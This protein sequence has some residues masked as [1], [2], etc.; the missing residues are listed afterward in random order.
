[1]IALVGPTQLGQVSVRALVV[2]FLTE[3]PAGSLVADAE[4][5]AV[6]AAKPNR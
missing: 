3:L 4:Q 1:M 5:E 2:C 6:L